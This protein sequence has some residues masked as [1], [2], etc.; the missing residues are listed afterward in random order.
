MNK[1]IVRPFLKRKTSHCRYG[2]HVTQHRWKYT[3]RAYSV[4]AAFR[5]LHSLVNTLI[6]Y[7]NIFLFFIEIV[8]NNRFS[9]GISQGLGRWGHSED[10]WGL[11]LTYC[12][13][14]VVKRFFFMLGRRKIPFTSS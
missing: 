3:F 1:K 11:A 6:D 9:R 4:T 13:A 7:K 14:T 8:R 5:L 2:T 12:H 10:R